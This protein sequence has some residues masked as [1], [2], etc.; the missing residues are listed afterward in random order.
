MDATTGW[1]ALGN[2]TLNLA[3]TKK[4]VLGTDALTFDK[5]NGAANTV[6]AGI[7]KTISSI[8]L[9]S[10]APHDIIQTVI[11][12]PDLSLVDYVFVRVGTDSSNYNEWRVPDASLIAA[13][14]ET[15]ALNIGDASHSGITG[16][17]WVQSAITYIAV[18][19]AFDAETNAL[20]GII[21]DELSFHTNQHTSASLNAEVTSEV[22]SANINVQK[23]GGSPTTKG[24]GN[25]GNGT[26]RIVLA[27]DDINTAAIK[28]AVEIIDNAISGSEMQ[29]DVVAA[30]PAGTNAIGKLAANSGVDIGDV[31]V[32]S[33]SAGST[34]IG[35]VGISGARTSG[36]TTPYKNIDVDESEDQIKGAAGQIYWIH[37][38]NLKASTVFLK[39]Y[40]LTAAAVTVGTTVPD[41]TFPIPTQGDTNGAGFT[42]SVPNGIAFGSAITIACTTGFADNDS[43]APGANE[44]IVNLGYA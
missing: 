25:V 35:D 39:I 27:T 7:Q 10:I 19:V 4:H 42:L 23:I 12:I 13:T 28:V 16:D 33:I 1:S 9:G 14:F 26:Q 21:F 17:G 44:C 18:G 37:C 5:V 20:A 34:L 31:D 40:D 22:S 6:F 38:M 15:L 11:Y 36:G 3:T 2:D 8:D 24:A 32:T 41:L 30:L 29:V 43:G